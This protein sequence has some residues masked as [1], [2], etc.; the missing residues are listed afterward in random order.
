[1][2][3]ETKVNETSPILGFVKKWGLNGSLTI[4]LTL[5]WGQKLWEKHESRLT[6]I[7]SQL[8]DSI[9]RLKKLEELSKKNHKLP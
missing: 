3:E 5:T 1:M 8:T 7:E 4:A 6:K 2:D 9:E